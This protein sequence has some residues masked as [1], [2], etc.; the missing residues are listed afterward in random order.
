M[1]LQVNAHLYARDENGIYET[2]DQGNNWTNIYT[3]K[4]DCPD[5]ISSWA[6]HPA[7]GNMLFIGGGATCAG[8]YQSSNGGQNWTL[9]GLE[10]KPNL[11]TLAIGLDEQGNFSVYTDSV[12]VTHDGGAKWSNIGV[13]NGCAI[14]TSDPDNPATIYCASDKLYVMPQKG[15]TWRLVPSTQSKFYSAIHIDHPNGVERL[16]TGAT[17]VSQDIPYFGIFISEDDGIS[18]VERNNGLGS[19]HAEL[20]IAPLDNARIYLATYY[21]GSGAKISCGLYRSNDKGTNWA[22]IKSAG[23]PPSWCGPAFD[24]DNV[25]FLM[26]TGRLQSSPNGGDTWLWDWHELTSHN[27]KTDTSTDRSLAF[28]LPSFY[29]DGL[30]FNGSQSVSANPYIKGLVYDVGDVIWYSID[31][32]VSWQLSSGSEGSED[33]RLFYTDQGK[34]IYAIGRYHQ[35]YSTDN[36]KIWQNCGGDVTASRSDTRLALDLDGSRLYLATPGQ[37]VLISTDS[38]GSWQP[39]NNGLSN[40]FVNTLAIDPNNLNTVYA[41]TDSGAYISYNS[42]ATWGQVNDGL[43]G[44]VVVYSIAVDKESN[45]YAATPYGVFKLEKK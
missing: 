32:G 9:I 5:A 19:A 4:K 20:I 15:D 30:Y 39:S 45:V 41:G 3:L 17:D 43:L 36:G 44:A 37:G 7:D 29:R 25:F 11:D 13:G 16:I 27:P 1:D 10:D 12:F 14:L 18:W 28:A 31:A 34:M 38:C 24:A 6:I 22:Q 26:D 2:K 8:V 40:L 21:A 35:K 42:G 33:G 23:Y